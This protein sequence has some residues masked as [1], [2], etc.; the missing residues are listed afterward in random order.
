[1]FDNLVHTYSMFGSSLPLIRIPRSSLVPPT[2]IF[3]QL[4]V[5]FFFV[6]KVPVLEEELM[7]CGGLW[8]REAQC[9]LRM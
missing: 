3:S 9:S 5:N 8:G 2:T 4:Q 1:M 6:H 7:A